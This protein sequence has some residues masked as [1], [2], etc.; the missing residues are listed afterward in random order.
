M[1]RPATMT[2]RAGMMGMGGSRY[3]DEGGMRGEAGGKVRLATVAFFFCCIAEL[4]IKPCRSS[5]SKL[6][7]EFGIPNTC[8]TGNK[9]TTKQQTPPNPKHN[10]KQKTGKCL[11][12]E[13]R[14]EKRVKRPKRPNA[15]IC[16]TPGGSIRYPLSSS[17]G[18]M[19]ISHSIVSI[20]A[21]PSRFAI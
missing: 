8:K 10:T 9:N 12:C 18:M 4:A 13:T 17:L 11:E 1:A 5:R 14:G 3:E 2:S 15:L 16:R 7:G 6:R 21:S 19:L 20:P